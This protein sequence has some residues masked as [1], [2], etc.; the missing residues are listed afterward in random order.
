MISTNGYVDKNKPKVR[1]KNNYEVFKEFDPKVNL[2][3]AEEELK[4]LGWKVVKKKRLL[5]KLKPLLEKI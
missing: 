1:G 4:S 3:L 5:I 2:K